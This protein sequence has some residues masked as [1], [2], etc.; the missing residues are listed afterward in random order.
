M[1]PILSYETQAGQPIRHGNVTLVPFARTLRFRL[2]WHFPGVNWGFG[3]AW[4]RPVSVL[5][6]TDDGQEQ[7]IP[8]RDVTRQ[9]QLGL[10]GACLGMA[11]LIGVIEVLRFKK[12]EK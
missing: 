11:I 3:L 6:V 10:V 9:V 7:V 8:V 5:A 4:S 12:T 1:A 2:P